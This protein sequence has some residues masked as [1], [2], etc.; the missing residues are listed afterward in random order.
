M[1][2][3]P[4]PTLPRPTATAIVDGAHLVALILDDELDAALEAGLMEFV[5]DPALAPAARGLILA[6]QR[7]LREAWD[8]RERYRARGA[9][10]ARR[11]AVRDGRRGAA[12]VAAAGKPALPPAA[13]A[14]LARAKARAGAP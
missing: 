1:R 14:A 9:R 3:A 10:L 7:R 6:M 5:D 8:A 12:P 13:A 4:D 11:K 2:P